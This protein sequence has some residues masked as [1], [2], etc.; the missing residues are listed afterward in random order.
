VS[1][2]MTRGCS[3]T[4]KVALPKASRAYNSV[5]DHIA[6]AVEIPRRGRHNALSVDGPVLRSDKRGATVGAAPRNRVL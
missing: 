4:V 2:G 1:F 5:N 6:R 3:Q